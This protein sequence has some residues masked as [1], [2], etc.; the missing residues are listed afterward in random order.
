MISRIGS[1]H[2]RNIPATVSNQFLSALFSLFTAIEAKAD[3]VVVS[4]RHAAN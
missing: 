3:A 4:R 1:P 2:S